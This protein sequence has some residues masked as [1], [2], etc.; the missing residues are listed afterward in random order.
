M[1][2]DTL[3]RAQRE[4]ALRII[5]EAVEATRRGGKENKSEAARSVGLKQQTFFKAYNDGD[6]GIDSVRKMATKLG[7]AIVGIQ[8]ERDVDVTP[9]PIMEPEDRYPSRPAALSAARSMG[10]SEHAIA[11]VA[12]LRA[13]GDVDPGIAAWLDQVDEIEAIL[14]SRIKPRPVDDGSVS[15]SGTSTM[16]RRR[17]P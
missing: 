13:K 12:A 3:T 11:A 6:I 7:R 17:S 16:V 8:P 5:R 2:G 10:K 4:E 9:S 15:S 1:A 14:A